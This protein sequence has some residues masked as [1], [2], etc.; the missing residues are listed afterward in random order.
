M[1]YI[2]V[3]LGRDRSLCGHL[4]VIG[5]NGGAICGPFP[6]A[7]RSSD[8]LALTSLSATAVAASS[9]SSPPAA[10][11]RSRKPTVAFDSRFTAAR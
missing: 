1:L 5:G 2:A 8:A 3:V 6:V 10:M 11:R 7:A 4:T 9:S